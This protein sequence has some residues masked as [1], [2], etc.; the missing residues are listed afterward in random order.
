MLRLLVAASAIVIAP[1]TLFAQDATPQNLTLG[2]TANASLGASDPQRG[3]RPYHVWRF[4]TDARKTLQIDMQSAAFDAVMTLQDSAGRFINTDD[5][6]GEGR[7]ARLS[8]DASPGTY[9]LLVRS[10]NPAEGMG[11]YTLKV[12]E[13]AET[14]EGERGPIARGQEITGTLSQGEPKFHDKPY[15]VYVL[16]G[17]EGDSITIELRSDAFDTYLILQDAFGRSI[18][19]NDDS[20]GELHSRIS[21][22]LPSRGR[23]R[24]VATAFEETAAGRFTLKVR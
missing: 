1:G 21:V 19:E 9:R 23:Y 4:R 5:N 8:F 11:D 12:S 16:E 22:R 3:G 6:S 20:D 10:S 15:H 17:A 2:Q 14:H 24:V 13:P 18:E 7:N